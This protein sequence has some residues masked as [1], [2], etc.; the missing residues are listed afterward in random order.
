MSGFTYVK[1]T[2]KEFRPK[3]LADAVTREF[4]GEWRT[5]L[6]TRTSKLPMRPL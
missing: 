4:C 6:I 5:L 2:L 3:D 1:G